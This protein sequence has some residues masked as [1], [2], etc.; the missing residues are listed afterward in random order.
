MGTSAGSSRDAAQ[1]ADLAGLDDAAVILLERSLLDP[2]VRRSPEAVRAL[3]H[4]D[5]SE[6]GASGQIWDADSVT[7]ALAAAPGADTI[8][9]TDFRGHQ[10]APGVLLLTFRTHRAGVS[11][12]RSSLWM[13]SGERWLLRFHQATAL[14]AAAPAP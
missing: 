14:P 3:L 5:F 7:A 4:P 13:R 1:E 12:L 2:Q 9:A 8:T 11:C 10:L 6:F